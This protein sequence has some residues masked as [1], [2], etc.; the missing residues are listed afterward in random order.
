MRRMMLWIRWETKVKGRSSGVGSGTNKC[1]RS[2]VTQ[3]SAQA[4]RYLCLHYVPHSEVCK[5]DTE[6]FLRLHFLYNETSRVKQHFT[7]HL[8]LDEGKPTYIVIA[9]RDFWR[10]KAMRH[11]A[12]AKHERACPSRLHL[13]FR[14]ST[15]DTQTREHRPKASSR[16][17]I[18]R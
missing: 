8:S 5:D 6:T 16:R 7:F 2:C 13:T 1:K 14:P 15:F 17:S 12:S 10:P 4:A 18:A 3:L 11:Q 9:R